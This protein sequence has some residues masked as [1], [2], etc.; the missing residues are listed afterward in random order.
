LSTDLDG[1]EIKLA[2]LK[3][4]RET[5]CLIREGNIDVA[6]EH[7]KSLY[8]ECEKAA[9]E[10]QRQLR[11]LEAEI[12]NIESEVSGLEQSIPP[13]A[14]DSGPNRDEAVLLRA[15][16]TRLRLLAPDKSLPPTE[17]AFSGVAGK[18]RVFL[19]FLEDMGGGKR[20][21]AKFDLPH[22]AA[23]EWEVIRTLRL[24]NVPH[25]TILPHVRNE[26]GDGV[27]I[28]PVAG[29]HSLKSFVDFGSYLRRT[30]KAAPDSGVRCLR[31][32]LDPLKY[33]YDIEP[34]A[35]RSR[36]SFGP[37]VWKQFFSDV[38]ERSV[39][40]EFAASVLPAVDWSAAD[41]Q[42]VP[43]GSLRPNPILRVERVLNSQTGDLRLSRI[44]GDLNLTN[45]LVCPDSDQTPRKVNIIDL[46]LSKTHEPSAKDLAQLEVAFWSEVFL[47]V[48]VEQGL[49]D[50]DVVGGFCS[51]QD[52]LDG[53][54]SKW[55][56][57][58]SDAALG[59]AKLVYQLRRWAFKVL[60]PTPHLQYLLTD[61]YS[62]LCFG[63][64][65]MLKY[66]LKQ[67]GSVQSQLHLVGAAVALNYLDDQMKGRYS[68]DARQRLLSPARMIRELEFAD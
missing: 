11:E 39:L 61:Y 59:T 46:A 24:L 48:S 1:A 18:S 64:M 42:F 21:I 9:F 28:Y 47:R 15:V 56:K 55:P 8:I 25:E 26:A 40:A 51:L 10:K 30:A 5:L 54:K 60:A 12:G 67:P 33:F 37:L 13:L 65:T 19:F 68:V 41:V 23:K 6:R 50:T 34:G 7:I 45:I 66:C 53:R 32:A 58:N 22:R 4:R 16:F 57:T 14:S 63:H 62:C 36:N 27:I 3:L 17:N 35:V 31:L 20:V 44:H 29:D 49:S 52:Y 43:R 38:P 2:L